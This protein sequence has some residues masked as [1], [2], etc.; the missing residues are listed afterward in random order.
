MINSAQYTDPLKIKL[1]QETRLNH[2]MIPP[3]W[4]LIFIPVAMLI[5]LGLY[6]I[7]SKDTIQTTLLQGFIIG[8]SFSLAYVFYSSRTSVDWKK[9]IYIR[10][11]GSIKFWASYGYAIRNCIWFSVLWRN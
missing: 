6:F 11:V 8:T 5:M 2:K 7:V 1:R 10:M 9:Q 3:F 4:I